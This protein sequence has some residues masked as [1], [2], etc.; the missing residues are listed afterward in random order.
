MLSLD[1]FE[2]Y[3]GLFGCCVFFFFFSITPHSIFVIHY[4]KY[5]NFL[6]PTLF[7][8]LHSA[9]YHSKFSTF[10]GPYTYNLVKAKLLAYPRKVSSPSFSLFSFPHP[11]LA[12]LLSQS[13][14]L[15]TCFLIFYFILFFIL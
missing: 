12:L 11:P 1:M 10:C 14:I 2:R 15:V 9:Y 8:T 13:P 5:P 4:L 6:Y 3:L 7:G